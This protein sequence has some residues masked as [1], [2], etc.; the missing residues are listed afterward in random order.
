MLEELAVYNENYD[1]IGLLKIS[2]GLVIQSSGIYI[3]EGISAQ[4]AESFLQ[5]NKEI[6]VVRGKWGDHNKLPELSNGVSYANAKSHV[7]PWADSKVE[8]INE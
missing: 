7:D 1:L 3:P 5:K 2:N 4:K 8:K 6:H